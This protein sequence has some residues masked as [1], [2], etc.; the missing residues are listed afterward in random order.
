[1]L[2]VEAEIAAGDWPMADWSAL[3]HAACAAALA[4]TPRGGLA[5][6]GFAIEV[7]VRLTDDAEVQAL[8]RQYRGKDAPTNILSFPMVQPDL[9]ETLANTDDG[10]ALLGDIALAAE[11]VAREAAARDWPMVDHARHLIVHGMLHLLGYD[12]RDAPA[13][14]HMEA[15][16]RAACSVLGIAD[17]YPGD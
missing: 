1:M 15:L 12:H 14:D 6:A 8:N 17:P 16:E 13:G 4:Q 5:R 7:A 3:A 9:L 10:E 11:T 2:M